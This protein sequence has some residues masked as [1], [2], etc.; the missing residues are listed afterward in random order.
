MIIF[1]LDIERV[2]FTK[3]RF[4]ELLRN[5]WIYMLHSFSASDQ[6]T[7][8]VSSLSEICVT[9]LTAESLEE[10]TDIVYVTNMTFISYQLNILLLL[11]ET[12][13]SKFPNHCTVNK[14]DVI[15]K[16]ID[17]YYIFHRWNIIH[18]NF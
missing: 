12:S 4:S 16:N 5:F 3:K 7:L 6:V 9:G 1:V 13:S 18:A 8:Q 14:V 2:K 11:F 17:T 10:C 15:Y